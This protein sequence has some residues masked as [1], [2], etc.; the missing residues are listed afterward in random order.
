[1]DTFLLQAPYY[2]FGSAN[3]LDKDVLLEC[4]HIPDKQTSQE[5]IN[6][7]R[8][9]HHVSWNI[10]LITI[11]D[12]VIVNTIPSKS[13][14]DGL[15]NALFDTYR[16]HIQAYPL[17]VTHKVKRHLLLN[18]YRCIRTVLTFCTRTQYR[19]V[20]RPTL[21]GIHPFFHKLDSLELLDFTTLTSFD[22]KYTNDID[23]WKTIPFYI[24]QT[25]A[26][27]DGVEIYTKDA[28]V[29]SFPQFTNFIYRQPLTSEDIAYLQQTKKQLATIL[30]TLPFENPESGILIMGDE[31]I[32][33]SLEVAL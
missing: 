30:R 17:P 31:K 22:A 27:L 8:Q 21:N 5:W 2:F 3:S 16:L 24:G 10:N 32:D 25:L 18:I 14:I 4:E 23:I 13:T 28:L 12:G 20:I 29:D 19:S 26:L 11:Q 6:A 7:Y 9:H 33:M 15:N 1:M